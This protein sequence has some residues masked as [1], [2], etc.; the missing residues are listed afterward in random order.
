MSSQSL[1]NGTARPEMPLSSKKNRK[2]RK[3]ATQPQPILKYAWLA[4]H[5]STLLFGFIYLSYYVV[6][7]SHKSWV[8]FAGYRLAKLPVPR[9]V[10]ALVFRMVVFLQAAAISANC[11]A[12]AVQPLPNQAIAQTG[13]GAQK[14]HRLQRIVPVRAARIRYTAYERKLRFWSHQLRHVL[15]AQTAAQRRQ[16]ILCLLGDQQ[17]G[18]L[19]VEAEKPK[20]RGGLGRG[21]EIPECPAEQVRVPVLG[22]ITTRNYIQ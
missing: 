17:T 3:K 22:R 1:P 6:R 18:H 2:L 21:Q 11:D 4:G 10:G 14:D 19:H 7:K 12:T 5:V 13:A 9:S 8:A 16:Q 15:L 20:N